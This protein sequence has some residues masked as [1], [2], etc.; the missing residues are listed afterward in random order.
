MQ[1]EQQRPVAITRERDGREQPRPRLGRHHLA[2]LGGPLHRAVTKVWD[3]QRQPAGAVL[4][5]RTAE[6]EQLKRRLVRARAAHQ[7][8]L[9]LGHVGHHPEVALSIGKHLALDLAALKRGER[10]ELV[11]EVL[12]L[13]CGEGDGRRH[14]EDL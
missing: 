11:A 5:Q 10:A 8:H 9:A 7:H 4:G 13:A 2:R 3:D 6:I 14:T 12:V 1:I